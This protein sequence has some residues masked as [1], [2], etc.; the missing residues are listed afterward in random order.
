MITGFLSFFFAFIISLI[1]FKEISSKEFALL[2]A[3]LVGSLGFVMSRFYL[4]TYFM[5]QKKQLASLS[6]A[7]AKK[8][9]S[10]HTSQE[11][12]LIEDENIY[13]DVEITEK[14]KQGERNP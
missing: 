5:K 2:I 13:R 14:G 4:K 3:P 8:M 11:N 1:V 10:F 7:L 12:I 6:K 9:Q